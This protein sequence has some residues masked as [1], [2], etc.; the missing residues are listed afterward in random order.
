MITSVI[1]EQPLKRRK[2]NIK[3]KENVFFISEE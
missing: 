1:L 3:E 2:K